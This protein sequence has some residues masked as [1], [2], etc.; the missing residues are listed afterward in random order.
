MKPEAMGQRA[1]IKPEAM[2]QRTSIQLEATSMA[3]S[4]L[5][6]ACL[7]AHGRLY[8]VD[9]SDVREIVRSQDLTPL[10]KAPKLIEGVIDLRGAMMPVV[11]LGRALEQEPLSES[12]HMRIVVLE[13]SEMTFGLRVEAAVD[14]VSV[15]PGDLCEPPALAMHTGYDAIRAVVRR[16][17]A[18]PVLILSLDHLLESIFVSAV[19]QRGDS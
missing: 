10:P 8:G 2:G 19:S 14:I 9:V 7:A 5:Q 6:M 15:Q 1:S 3:E 11:D 4:A 16:A 13:V 18:P 17:G 12:S